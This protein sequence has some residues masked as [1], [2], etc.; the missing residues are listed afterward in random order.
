VMQRISTQNIRIQKWAVGIGAILLLGKFFAYYVTNSST[1][2]TD[3]LESIINV[4]AGALGLYSL[5]LSARPKDENHPYGHGKVE[6]ISAGVEGTLIFLAG[7]IIIGQAIWSLVF[8]GREIQQIDIGIYITT[9]AGFVNYALGHLTERQGRKSGSQALIASG[10]HL[11]SDAYSTIGMIVGLIAILLVQSVW[12]SNEWAIVLDNIVA[13]VFGGIIG[14]TGYGILRESVA[15]IMDEVDYSLVE[16]IVDLLNKNRLDNW[17][18]VHNLRIIKYGPAL[19]IDCHIT[20]PW[21]YNAR[22]AHDEVDRLEEVLSR[23]IDTEVE[24]F[25]HVDPC[26]PSSCHLCQLQD[27]PERQEAFKEKVLWKADNIM[28]N[29]KHGL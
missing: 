18:D 3:A 9:F 24:L 11:K 22:E 8:G 16:E 19:H 12:K 26:I 2:L 21:Y 23:C 15:G 7:I 28:L 4:V 20:L 29:R 5:I 1:V 27:C 17:I 14:W 10:K 13:I 6:F 25:V